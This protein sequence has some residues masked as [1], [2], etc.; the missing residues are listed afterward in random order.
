M[1]EKVRSAILYKHYFKDF[2]KT[3]DKKS[4]RKVDWTIKLI[5]HQQFVPIEYFKKLT[6]TDDIWEIRVKLG[7]N[8][9]RIF[10]FFDEEN[11][12]ILENG[13]QKKKQKTPK[14]EI[15]KAERIK[16]EYFN[17]KK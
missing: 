14:S 4:K 13:F 2:Y 10:C 11:L 9:F 3:L 7:S 1:S 8:I 5:E 16:K 17:E 12:I 6:D 15:E